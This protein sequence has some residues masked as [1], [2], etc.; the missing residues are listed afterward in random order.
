M[1]SRNIV[2]T[3]AGSGIGRAT[4]KVLAKRGYGLLLSDRNE[5]GLHE[6][7]S[8]L[9]TESA[10]ESRVVDVT[11]PDSVAALFAQ[12]ARLPGGIRGCV[13]SAGV[14]GTSTLDTTEA[15][16]WERILSINLTGTF[17]V[18]AE[19]AKTIGDGG[20]IVSISSM[21]AQT[22]S[23]FAS[24]AYAASKAGVVGLTRSLA[25]PLAARGIR[26]NSVSPGAIDTNMLAEFGSE[27]RESLKGMNPMGRLGNPDEIAS[28]IEF[29]VSDASSFVTGQVLAVNGGAF[30][31]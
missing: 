17:H 11:D 4:A 7:V 14:V 19:S 16:E 15:T 3:G 23:R 26:I 30:L 29:L 31:G 28:T 13:H 27:R 20:S 18:I 12:A 5:Q 21:A 2:V 24:P 1:T 10:V 8:E 22:S 6:T 25:A 9:A